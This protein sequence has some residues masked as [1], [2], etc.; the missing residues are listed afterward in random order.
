M[1]LILLLFLGFVIWEDKLHVVFEQFFLV[2]LVVLV[3]G[4]GN[5]GQKKQELHA[6]FFDDSSKH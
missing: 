1:H 6:S 5:S 3:L 2:E 4:G